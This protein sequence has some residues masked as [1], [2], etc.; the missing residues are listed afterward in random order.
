M[1]QTRG[2]DIIDSLNRNHH[3][4]CQVAGEDE[5]RSPTFPIRSSRDCT[6]KI[7]AQTGL[8]NIHK[9][10]CAI[11]DLI[12]NLLQLCPIIIFTYNF[13]HARVRISL[14]KHFGGLNF[15]YCDWWGLCRAM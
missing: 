4:G 9:I 5:T 3:W 13:N 14:C 6:L 2:G 10:L 11:S 7:I 15:H 8:H 1:E 12:T